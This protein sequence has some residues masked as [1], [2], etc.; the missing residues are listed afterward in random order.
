MLFYFTTLKLAWVTKGCPCFKGGE[1]NMQV[2]ALWKLGIILLL[3]A[4]LKNF[5]V[6]KVYDYKIIGTKIVVSEGQDLQYICKEYM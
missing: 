1:S 2:H 3:Y 5:V 4:S 6:N